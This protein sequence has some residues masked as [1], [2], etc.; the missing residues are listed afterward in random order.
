M[1]RRAATALLRRADKA[2]ATGVHKSHTHTRGAE[3]STGG[4]FEKTGRTSRQRCCFRTHAARRGTDGRH[5]ISSW[6]GLA[7]PKSRLFLRLTRLFLYLCMLCVTDD[8]QWKGAFWTS[9]KRWP[10]WRVCRKKVVLSS[11]VSR[12]VVSVWRIQGDVW[13]YVPGSV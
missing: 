13:S 2:P 8:R 9:W 4:T 3:R 12:S 11:H 7:P 6:P 10:V 5:R 1:D